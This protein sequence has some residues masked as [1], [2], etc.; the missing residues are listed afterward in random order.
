MLF[1]IVYNPAIEVSWIGRPG[2]K[3]SVL[4]KNC[5]NVAENKEK[6]VKYRFEFHLSSYDN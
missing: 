6:N 5:W 1:G 3:K 4:R 2:D